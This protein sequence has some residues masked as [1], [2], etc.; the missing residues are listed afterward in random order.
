MT[1]EIIQEEINRIY[2]R[3]ENGNKVKNQLDWQTLIASDTIEFYV[4]RTSWWIHR[5]RKSWFFQLPFSGQ[6]F[7]F[8]IH[9]TFN[10]TSWYYRYTSRAFR[11]NFQ[12]WS[13]GDNGQNPIIVTSNPVLLQSLNQHPESL[14]YEVSVFILLCLC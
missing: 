14:G 5:Y 6:G 3:D 10:K 8:C 12:C 2:D 13:R 9:L 7:L 1:E 11:D 4:E